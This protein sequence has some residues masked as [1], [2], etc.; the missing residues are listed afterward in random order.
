MI[1]GGGRGE[2]A[3]GL[4]VVCT[5]AQQSCR[6]VA[7]FLFFV[8]FLVP[9]PAVLLVHGSPPPFFLFLRAWCIDRCLVAG[10][11]SIGIY[12]SVLRSL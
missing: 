9:T 7:V 5:E 8:C 3:K 4:V 12:D 6:F 11:K 10:S 1:G 2:G